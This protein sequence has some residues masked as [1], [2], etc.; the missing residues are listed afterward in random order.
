MLSITLIPVNELGNREPLPL[1]IRLPSRAWMACLRM[2]PSAV[3][4]RD[5]GTLPTMST[6]TTRRT[7]LGGLAAVSAIACKRSGDNPAGSRSE[8]WQGIRNSFPFREDRVPMNAANLCPSPES[9][10]SAVT[11]LTRSIDV[12]CSFQNRARFEADRERARSL[13]AAQV[14]ADP[15][16]VALVRNTSEANNIVNNGLDLGDG[17]EVVFWDQ[18]HPTN[19]V[20]WQVRARRSGFSLRSVSVPQDPA[21][22]D[23]LVEPFR[24]ALSPRTRVLALTHASNTSGIRLPVRELCEIAHR[25]GI[26][27]HVDGAQTWGAMAVDLHALGCDSYAASAHKWYCGPKEV[28]LLYVRRERID[29]IWPSTV[30]PGWGTGADT[31][32]VGARKFESMGQR[33]DAAISALGN[34]ADFHDAIGPE[35]TESRVRELASLL[36]HS[37]SELGAPLVTP[38]DE[39]LSA[40]VCIMEVG[41]DNRGPVFDAMYEQHGIAGSTAGGF[42]LCP[43]I[44]NTP[45]HIERAVDGLAELRH[46]WA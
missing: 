41:P 2:L 25:Q 44:Y 40:G 37:L 8:Y 14:G 23:E 43:H 18:N 36:K 4:G 6:D 3:P 10:S 13:V 21:G 22:P 28:G 32:L 38:L 7:F 33:D 26:H 29:T 45:S 16:E 30:A 1:L 31:E 24:R 42:R 46:I 9:V 17:D 35:R 15:D 5:S 19:N 12:D 34:A 39:G 11:D 27:V 20:A